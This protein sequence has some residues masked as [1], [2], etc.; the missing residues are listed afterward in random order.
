MPSQAVQ[1]CA[2]PGPFGGPAYFQRLLW[3]L[4]CSASRIWPHFGPV[5]RPFGHD[6]DVQT[7]RAPSGARV[8]LPC[9]MTDTRPAIPTTVG[10]VPL[11]ESVVFLARFLGTPVQ[12]ERL[13]DS[14]ASHDL[15]HAGSLSPDAMGNL[16]QHAGL[17]GSP[18]PVG[19]ARRTTELPALLLGA[20]GA[21]AGAAADGAG[22]GLSDLLP[23]DGI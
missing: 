20:G 5:F 16:L 10:P 17:V 2:L 11:H 8:Q 4:A 6:N 13:R 21:A 3:L 1:A 15:E 9:A 19:A 12:V 23:N 18:L 14:L 7:A 22:A